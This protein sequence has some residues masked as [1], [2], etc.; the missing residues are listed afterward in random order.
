MPARRRPPA[1][2][3]LAA[4]ATGACAAI[5]ALAG[6]T[7]D[8]AGPSAGAAGAAAAPSTIAAADPAPPRRV[9]VE[10]LA[11][12]PW[13]PA[14]FTQGLEFDGPDLLVGTGLHGES[15]LMRVTAPPGPPRVLAE[16]PL[17][18]EHFGEGIT[19]A[20]ASIWQLTWHA[21]V[22][23]RSTGADLRPD[24]GARYDG[25]G[26]GL[27][28]HAPDDVLVMSDGTGTLTLRDP[29]DLSARTAV[30]VA[31]G[32]GGDVGKLNE[33]ECVAA[34]DLPAGAGDLA[35]TWANRWP[36]GELLLIDPAT[37]AVRATADASA[38]RGML[39][40]EGSEEADVLNG[41]AHVPG[42]DRFLLAGKRW[43]TLFEVR[44]R[45]ADG[46]R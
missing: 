43:P 31:R 3:A 17:P 39:P 8:T 15:A 46:G 11:E 35:G 41:I 29:A 20:G 19:V 26:W 9:E 16:R 37:G 33:L 1:R 27:C 36:T 45:P 38:L 34:A 32:D 30:E 23:H 28:H 6:C 22:A 13:N 7:A 10:V 42:T 25:E 44:F 18:A 5:P 24:G 12:H 4:L 21:G 2:R 14:W 40:A